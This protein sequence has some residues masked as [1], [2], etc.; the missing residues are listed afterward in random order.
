MRTRKKISQ[1]SYELPRYRVGS[2]VITKYDD[3]PRVVHSLYFDIGKHWYF[4]VDGSGPF[5][6]T[7]LK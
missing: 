5:A 2:T 3:V 1:K 6:E 4:M 7:E